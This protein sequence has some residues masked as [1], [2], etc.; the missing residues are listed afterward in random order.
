MSSE[1]HA[2]IT[3]GADIGDLD[4]AETVQPHLITLRKLLRKYCNNKYAPE[5]DEFAPIGRIDGEFGYWEFEGTQK[6]RLSKK[7]RYITI[8][9]GMPK[10]RWQG[11]SPIEIRKYLLENLKQAL[12]LIVQRLKKEKYDVDDVR[13]F[14]DFEKVEKEYLSM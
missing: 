13:L 4:A 8:D 5:L 3:F 9:I 1:D 14:Q 10:S 7:H 6:L 11:V 2:Y 12:V